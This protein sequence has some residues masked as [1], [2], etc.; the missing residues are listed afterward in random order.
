MRIRG[1]AHATAVTCRVVA[2]FAVLAIPAQ[3]VRGQGS[4]ESSTPPEVTRQIERLRSP[5]PV[6]RGYAA[7]ELGK[8]G[9]PAAAAV[10]ALISILGDNAR[11]EESRRSAGVTVAFRQGLSPGRLAAEA[12]GDIGDK[13]AVDPL[14]LRLSHERRDLRRNA[15]YALGLLGDDRAVKPLV[16]LA[17]NKGEDASLRGEAAEALGRIGHEDAIPALAGLFRDK[18]D[19][20]F[21]RWKATAGLGMMDHQ[22]AID[23]VIQALS[24]SHNYV[25]N[26]AAHAPNVRVARAVEPLIKALSDEDYTIQIGAATALGQIRDR[27]AISPLIA[28]LKDGH[29]NARPDVLTALRKITGQNLGE[30]YA[31]WQNWWE[32]TKRQ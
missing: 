18:T 28:A 15:A 20:W 17:G 21:V 29:K 13:R 10:P 6:E 25:R 30:D 7:L 5:D 3:S 24:D 23:T 2:V 32:R 11:L 22:E 9:A 14:I 16:A 31:S 4:Q 8:L 19:D 26:A 27:R 1:H 12:L